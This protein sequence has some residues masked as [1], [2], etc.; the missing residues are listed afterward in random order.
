MAASVVSLA[1]IFCLL[2]MLSICPFL[3]ATMATLFKTPRRVPL[4]H[5][6]KT[7]KEQLAL[8]LA[9]RCFLA[10]TKTDGKAISLAL[11]SEDPK[12]AS[13]KCSATTCLLFVD[14]KANGKVGSPA[15]SAQDTM[16][17]V[18]LS[19]HPLAAAQNVKGALPTQD[20]ER[21][22][23]ARFAIIHIFIDT[24]ATF[25]D[26]N[27]DTHVLSTKDFKMKSDTMVSTYA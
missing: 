27:A 20:L 5:P 12:L 18:P 10:D 7:L 1:D 11:S 14:S 19:D 13:E 25:Q 26:S 4:P 24:E 21:V 8:V 6:L 23:D 9:I 2:K 3:R 16:A 17:E 15:P 22:V